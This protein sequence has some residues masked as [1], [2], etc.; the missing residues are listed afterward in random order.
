MRSRQPSILLVPDPH[1]RYLED[2]N[3]L[4]FRKVVVPCNGK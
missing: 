2:K 1:S 4:L 3:I